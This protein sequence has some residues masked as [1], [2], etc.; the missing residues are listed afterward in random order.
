MECKRE[1]CCRRITSGRSSL[2]RSA[3]QESSIMA[4]TVSSL[5][6][7]SQYLICAF[8]SFSSGVPAT[9]GKPSLPKST[10]ACKYGTGAARHVFDT[11]PQPNQRRND[12]AQDGPIAYHHLQQRRRRHPSPTSPR[13][14]SF[15]LRSAFERLIPSTAAAAVVGAVALMHPPRANRGEAG[16]ENALRRESRQSRW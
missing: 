15:V 14:L 2:S 9:Q 4:S 7:S 13:V 8:L 3:A 10:P 16:N 6:C 1:E 12:R 5:E 11:Y